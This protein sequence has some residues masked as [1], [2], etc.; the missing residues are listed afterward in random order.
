M[1]VSTEKSSFMTNSTNII[2][3]NIRMNYQNLG[4]VISF[5]YLGATLC[6]NGTCSAEVLTRIISAM[7]AIARLNR[8]WR[9]NI[10]SFARKF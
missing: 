9:C 2:S 8:I 3:A 10:I 4:E 1:E 7:A 6:K 5:K